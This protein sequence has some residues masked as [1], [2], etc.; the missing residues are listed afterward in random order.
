[1][2]RGSVSIYIICED[3]VFSRLMEFM[4]NKYLAEPVIER[5]SSFKEL[6][7]KKSERPPDIVILDDY[8]TGAASLEVITFIRFN[9]RL[10]CPVYLFCENVADMINKALQRGANHCYTKPFKPLLAVEEIIGV[11]APYIA[12]QKTKNRSVDCSTYHLN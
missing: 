7:E 1:M 6:K 11:L 8:N 12:G 5:I 10:E 2:I 4:F 3:L 9:K